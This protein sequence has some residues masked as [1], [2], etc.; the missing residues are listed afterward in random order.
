MKVSYFL[1]FLLISLIFDFFYI[2]VFDFLVNY[3]D[4][5]IF[6]INL[7]NTLEFMHVKSLRNLGVV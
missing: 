5:Y 1:S 3:L 4:I 6:C 7:Y 2:Y